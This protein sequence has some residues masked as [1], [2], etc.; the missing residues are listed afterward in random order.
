MHRGPADRTVGRICRGMARNGGADLPRLPGLPLYGALLSGLR[1][2]ACTSGVGIREDRI[3]AFV[4]SAR[5]A[6]SLLY[7]FVSGSASGVETSGRARFSTALSPRV[8]LDHDPLDPVSCY[9]G[10]CFIGP[11]ISALL[12]E[13]VS[14][15]GMDETP[16][17]DFYLGEER[18]RIR[19]PIKGD[20]HFPKIFCYTERCKNTIRS[21]I[22]FRADR[23]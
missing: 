22:L 19:V 14:P 5:P 21:D 2:H 18:R 13:Y 23:C 4:S 10:Q 8:S 15:F 20:V 17:G 11:R 6:G 7:P 16:S 12:I 3:F 1:R 9:F